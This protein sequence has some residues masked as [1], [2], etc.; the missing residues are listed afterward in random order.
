[1][2]RR[3][4]I[5]GLAGA[6]VST[7]YASKFALSLEAKDEQSNI[8]VGLIADLHFGNLAPDGIDRFKVFRH[9]V[10]RELP[11][12]VVQLGDF[13]FGEP[14]AKKL[15]DEWNAI[16][17]DKYHVLGN[18]DMDKDTKAEIQ[19][20]WGM[21]SRYYHFEQNGW[22]FVVLDMNHL[23]KGDKYIPY[24]N[25]NFYVDASLRTWADPAQLIWLDETLA[26]SPLPVIIYTHQPIGH[27]PDSPQQRPILDIIKKHTTSR[28]R[29]KT[30]AVICG[31]QH[32]DWHLKLDGVHHVCINSASYLWKDGKPWPYTDALFTFMEIRDGSLAFAGMNTTWKR[33]PVGTE[34]APAISGRDIDLE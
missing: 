29:P 3:T 18:H 9:A 6:G 27:R 30:R 19:K 13:C 14:A 25:A 1:M 33:R 23:K 4:L 32:E 15:M 5:S 8:K 17:T 7:V 34:I 11:D 12:H 26:S 20:F 31:H 21:K 24:G 28:D 2:K 22:R 10:E 16:K